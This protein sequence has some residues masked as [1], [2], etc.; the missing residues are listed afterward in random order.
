MGTRMSI[1]STALG[2]NEKRR[3][4]GIAEKQQ[5]PPDEQLSLL[6]QFND[7]LQL[8]RKRELARLLRVNPWTIDNW[9]KRGRIPAPVCISPQIVAWRRTDID[10]WLIERQLQPAKTR[11]VGKRRAR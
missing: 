2:R 6:S 5:P 9:R 7:P 10:R 3:G 8:I 1:Q 11:D 4:K